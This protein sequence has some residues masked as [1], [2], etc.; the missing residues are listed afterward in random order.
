M[1]VKSESHTFAWPW[2]SNMQAALTKRTQCLTENAPL[3]QKISNHTLKGC[4]HQ[5][6]G[7]ALKNLWESEGPGDYLDR[8]LVEYAAAS[9]HF[10]QADHKRYRANVENNLGL[11]ISQDQPLQRS[12]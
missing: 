3:F 11:S 10:E 9:Y 7:D 5:T 2:L 8:A 6:L 4:Y 12:T 1:R